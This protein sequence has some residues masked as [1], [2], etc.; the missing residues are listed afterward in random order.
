MHTLSVRKQFKPHAIT[1]AMILA[2]S[3]QAIAEESTEPHKSRLETIKVTSQKTEETLLKVPQSLTVIT[4][5]EI[6]QQGINTLED[7]AGRVPSM[8]L[9]STGLAG[10]S[11]PTMRGL[12]AGIISF[13]TALPIYIDG[14]PVLNPVGYEAAL[15]DIEQIEVLR[16]PQGTFYGRNAEVGAMTITSRKPDNEAWGNALVELGQRNKRKLQLKASTPLIKDTLYISLAGD[17][18]SQDGNIKNTF[19]NEQENDR[20]VDNFRAQLRWTP[21]PKTDINLTANALK[22][23]GGGLSTGLMSAPDEEVRSNEDTYNRSKSSSFS[24][25]VEHEFENQMKLT[26][27]T[28][29]R[30][31][32]DDVNTD[33]D[34][35]EMP[36]SQVNKYH[37][38]NR[39]S[40]EIRLEN[41]LGDHYWMAGLYADV[42]DNLI[43]FN[44]NSLMMGSLVS[45]NDWNGHVEALFTH[46]DFKLSEPLHL[47]VGARHEK[48]S[49]TLKNRITK[50]KYEGDWSHT[51]PKVSLS[52]TEGSTTSYMTVAEGFRSGGF[53]TLAPTGKEK[54]DEETLWSYEL[55]AKSSFFNNKLDLSA[56]VYYMD[57]DNMQ[58]QENQNVTTI[59]ISN[60]AKATSIGAEAE[61]KAYLDNWQLFGHLALNETKFDEF[62]DNLGNYKNNYAPYAPK[63]TFNLGVRYE[64]PKN[65]YGQ[66]EVQGVGDFYIAK[67]NNYKQDA[68]QLVN[69]M[70]G[71]EY[72]QLNAALYARNLFDANYDIEGEFNGTQRNYNPPREL[73]VR[74][75]Y[76]F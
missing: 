54:Y 31:W 70:L 29:Q 17:T 33:F 66:V 47:Q 32:E 51:S 41:K 74:L 22:H 76:D 14:I 56:S 37:E 65:W 75:S 7:V 5:G 57:I 52:Y 16:G 35:T 36:M 10:M 63:H 15:I 39:L 26:S 13:T 24:L 53:N 28:A 30:T 20:H 58:V 72:K 3:G 18:T 61:F 34:L 27:V 60:A 19:K 42:D 50:V 64:D 67:Q 21:T 6:E 4:G 55:G 49:Q 48:N 12:N 46:W 8:L 43:G 38:F 73:G 69:A 71:Y 44:S 59:F 45:Q 9:P 11:K 68:Y 2:F 62:Q 25:S 23:D 1:W 40:Q